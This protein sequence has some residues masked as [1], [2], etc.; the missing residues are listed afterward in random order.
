MKMI[1]IQVVDKLGAPAAFGS[2]KIR[3]RKQII[4]SVKSESQNDLHE[5]LTDLYTQYQL[6]VESQKSNGLKPKSAEIRNKLINDKLLPF[7]KQN[8][9]E[10][11]PT[12]VQ[13]VSH[14]T[15]RATEKT[16][17]DTNKYS[18]EEVQQLFDKF[19]IP[20]EEVLVETDAPQSVLEE[21]HPVFPEGV[22]EPVVDIFG[23]EDTKS[24]NDPF[25]DF[26]L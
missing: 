1:E 16:I 18:E 13:V 6:E 21:S 15:V 23:E 19:E 26:E 7:V 9:G 5:L 12:E 3:V 25:S 14:N 24:S 20:E 10:F 8:A 17:T 4:E 11:V 22:D 2:G